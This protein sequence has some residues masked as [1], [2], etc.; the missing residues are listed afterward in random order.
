MGGRA[1]RACLV[2]DQDHRGAALS[3]R[4]RGSTRLEVGGAVQCPRRRR[5]HRGRRRRARAACRHRRQRLRVHRSHRQRLPERLPAA[6]SGQRS[7]RRPRRG[8]PKRRSL[9]GPARPRPVGLASTATVHTDCAWEC[10]R[11]ASRALD[12]EADRLRC[13]G[14]CGRRPLHA[15][16]LG[17][18]IRLSGLPALQERRQPRTPDS[19]RQGPSEAFSDAELVGHAP[20]ARGASRRIRAPTA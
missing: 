5:D 11:S 17:P 12:V 10:P 6:A 1:R 14:D 20:S 4:A 2:S 13:P 7:H 3:A 19:R 9:P 16:F 15:G 8:L 18:S